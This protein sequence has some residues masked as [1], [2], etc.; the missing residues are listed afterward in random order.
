MVE[1]TIPYKNQETIILDCISDGVI[2]IDINKKV[3]YTNKAMNE[4][5]ELSK[6][7][8][9]GKKITCSKLVKCN[10]NHSE[11]LLVRTMKT[12]EKISNYEMLIT[13]R[14][15]KNIA[16]SVN[17]D[18]LIND[19]GKLI[20]IVEVFRDISL[21]KELKEKLEETSQSDNFNN[22]IGKSK[23]MRDILDLIPAIAHS[24]STVLIE[25]ESGTGKE[26]IANSIHLN[27][28][29]RDKPFVAVNCAVLAEGVLESEL[30]GHV[31]GAFTGAY[32]DKPGRFELANK[33]TLFLDEIGDISPPLQAKLLRVLQEEEFEKVG[34]IKVVKVDVRIIA[35]SNKNL[36]Q[37]VKMGEF[38]E[39][40]YYRIR[41]LPIY[42][43]PLRER[44]EDVPLLIK[45]YIANFNKEMDKGINNISPKAMDILLDYD[46]PGNV[47]ELGNIIE[48][49]FVCCPENTILAECLPKDIVQEDREIVDKVARDEGSLELLEKELIIKALNQS[50]WSSKEVC[51]R[52]GISRTTLWRKMKKYGI[53][54]I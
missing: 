2:T 52:L 21:I 8:L 44:R 32:Y 49:A 20:G 39:D 38:R 33:G 19:E 11:C 30:F 34:G 36:S 53:K 14:S 46:Y 16:V 17:T 26:L 43:P 5:L 15:G 7:D 12:G 42:I 28:P 51:N 50:I 40:L 37:A 3:R 1:E 29:R 45:H 48:H 6:N 31:K 47:R 27:G 22:I 4:L 35:A 54:R 18:M 25:G 13:S 10:I 23:K 41:V 24:K 9:L